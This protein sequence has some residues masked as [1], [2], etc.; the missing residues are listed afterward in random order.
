MIMIALA[1]IEELCEYFKESLVSL[2][3]A[4]K[5]SCRYID[6]FTQLQETIMIVYWP[7]GAC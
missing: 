5:S 2:T 1:K 3:H 6:T 7:I 4:K